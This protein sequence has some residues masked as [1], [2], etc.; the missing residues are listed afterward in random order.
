[1]RYDEGGNRLRL[2]R[3][4]D[5]GVKVWGAEQVWIA[6]DVALEQIEPGAEIY[7]AALSGSELFIGAGARIGIS[8]PARI[9]DCQIGRGCEIGAG[10]YDGATFLDGACIRGFAEV[11]PG[12]LLEE[13]TEAAHSVAFKNT[14]LTATCVAGS[15]INY[16]DVFM[17]GG[18][19]RS[20]HSEV[21]SGAIHFNFDPRGDKWGSLIGDV[22]GVLHR[23]APIFIGG[24]AGLVGPVAVGFGAVVAAGSTIRHDVPS[25]CVY[26]ESDTGGIRRSEGFDRRRYGRVRRRLCLTARLAGTYLALWNWYRQVRIPFASNHESLLYTAATRQ[27]ELNLRERARRIDRLIDKLDYSISLWEQEGG[28]EELLREQRR[29]RSRRKELDEALDPAERTSSA[30]PPDRFLEEY[31]RAR[32]SST[33]IEALSCLSKAAS[34]EA[35][36]WLRSISSPSIDQVTALISERPGP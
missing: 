35:E 24:Q 13:Q 25:D 36:D 15:L 34:S 12:T 6:E 8:G 27:I 28:S 32:K 5:R 29:V 33:H 17:S 3:L 9:S 7:Q 22:R 19:S 16:C 21:G 18:T 31:A 14:I 10:T 11:R 30:P 1:M 23:Q 20:D 2:A 4:S 26:S